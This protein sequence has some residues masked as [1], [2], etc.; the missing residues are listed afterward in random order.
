MWS[1]C[2][3][4]LIYDTMAS[5]YTMYL[6]GPPQFRAQYT[7]LGMLELIVSGLMLRCPL[8]AF[9]ALRAD[10]VSRLS[11]APLDRINQ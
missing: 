1:F 7:W 10:E 8:A 3:A 5:L 6:E 4:A 2:I 11:G 9:Q